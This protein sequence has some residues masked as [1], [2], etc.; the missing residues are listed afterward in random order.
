[1]VILGVTLV[2]LEGTQE[3]SSIFCL[4]C[5]DGAVADG[6]LNV[7]LFLPLGAALTIGGSRPLRALALGAVLSFGVET[8][9]F[10]IPGRDPSLSDLVFN[11]LGTAL[12]VALA[13]STALWWRPRPRMAGILSI[14][15][16][17]S[18]AS[19][20]AST[21]FLLRPS[22]P[23]DTYYGGWTPRFDHLEW[24]GGRVLEASLGGLEV[25]PGVLAR[26]PQVRQELL[27]GATIHV[28]ARA[29][30]RPSGLAPVFTIDDAH[31][32]E[33]LLFGIVGAELV[34]RYRP[35]ALACRLQAPEIR[36]RGAMRG[37][38]WRDLVSI[39]V[40]PT[41]SGYCV[42][43]NATEHCGLGFTVGTGWA[44]LLG[45]PPGSL[46]LQPALNPGWLAALFFPI[47]RWARF[48]WAFAASVAL[49]LGGL[50]VLPSFVG[51]L[52]TPATELVG[53]L[54][55]SLAGWT[56]RKAGESHLRTN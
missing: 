11:T 7:G 41:G 40:R 56:S 27:S 37:I 14:V 49:S 25:P 35:R 31:Q 10:V 48:S 44:L 33:I 50:L 36:V 47:G 24:Y 26:S 38:V 22:F 8:A 4:L 28:R 30:P 43:V 18:A 45:S 2:P 12:G 34:Y 54:A 39:V 29:G 53:A 20:L 51:L 6:L 9:Q 13:R 32:R 46:W 42:R 17:L 1:V 21:G 19:V 5:G 15:G 16:A 3:T 52:P 55:G 23:E